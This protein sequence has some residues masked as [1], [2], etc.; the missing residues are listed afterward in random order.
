MAIAIASVVITHRT[1]H[2]RRRSSEPPRAPVREM[3]VVRRTPRSVLC[4][5]RPGIAC[6]PL[7]RRPT[8]DAPRAATYVSGSTVSSSRPASSSIGGACAD[9][10]LIGCDR[11]LSSSGPKIAS[12]VALCSG[13]KSYGP[14]RPITPH[15]SRCADRPSAQIARIQCKQG[16]DLPSRRMTHQEQAAR[17][18]AESLSVVARPCRRRRRIFHGRRKRTGGYNR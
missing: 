2:A 13:R 4:G 11:G 7:C 16:S 1:R 17:I 14:A 18:A 9:T 6:L 3:S 10:K 12:S 15:M 8:A 5:R